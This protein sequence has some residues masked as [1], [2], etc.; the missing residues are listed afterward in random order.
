MIDDNLKRENE[1][2]RKMLE[3]LKI[4]E[5]EN[6]I[7]KSNLLK[8]EEKDFILNNSNA[9]VIGLISDQSVKAEIAWGVAI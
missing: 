6:S 8:K 5:K 9:F 7:L 3:Y 4:V 2:A 1:I